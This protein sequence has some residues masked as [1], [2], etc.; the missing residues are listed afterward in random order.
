MGSGWENL[1][2][3]VT[4]SNCIGPISLNLVQLLL[5]GHL[6]QLVFVFAGL[7]FLKDGFLICTCLALIDSSL[8]FECFIP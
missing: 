2:G 6:S 3:V 4:F 5:M 7:L 1:E 8:S